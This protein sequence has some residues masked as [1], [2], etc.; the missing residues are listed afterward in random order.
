VSSFAR[1]VSSQTIATQFDLDNE[2]MVA[3]AEL[4]AAHFYHPQAPPL[5]AIVDRGLLQ[6]EEAMRMEWSCGSFC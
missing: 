1:Q 6:Q 3:T 5:G 4:D 2:I